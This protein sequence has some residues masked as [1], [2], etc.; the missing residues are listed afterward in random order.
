M[1]LAK[2]IAHTDHPRNF[3]AGLLDELHLVS[4]REIIKQGYPTLPRGTGPGR[5]TTSTFI[6][7]TPTTMFSECALMWFWVSF[8]A[9][10]KVYE[11][12][13]MLLL[14]FK[15]VLFEHF[16]LN[17]IIFMFGELDHGYFPKIWGWLEKEEKKNIDR[18]T[19]CAADKKSHISQIFNLHLLFNKALHQ[20]FIKHYRMCEIPHLP[21]QYSQEFHHKPIP[22]VYK[23]YLLQDIEIHHW[24][25]SWFLK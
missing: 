14:L 20:F 8:V 1:A 11:I 5:F 23:W 21:F 18:K 16:S 12:P 15:L 17:I 7:I 6:S 4:H 10:Y 22:L 9:L 25:N 19:C 24:Y 3:S 13:Q 2:Y